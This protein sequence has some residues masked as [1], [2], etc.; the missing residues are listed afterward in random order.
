[1]LIIKTRDNVR[2][3]DGKPYSAYDV[4]FTFNLKKKF[5]ALDGTGNWKYLKSVTAVDSNHVEFIFSR[6]YVPGFEVLA[7]QPI[8]PKHVWSN[9]DDPV[10]Y[11]DPNPIGTGPFTEIVK[12]TNQ[13]WELGK[14]PNYWQKGKPKIDKLR[15]PAFLSNEQATLAL[16]KGEVDWSGNFIPAID[17]IF[18]SKDPE[19]NKYWFPKSGGSIFLLSLIHI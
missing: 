17:R 2:W 13:V 10:K 6:I 11:T 3:S 1:M 18:V 8:V 5:P 4:E 7:G 19:H 12:F 9:V 16:I 14:N 15:F